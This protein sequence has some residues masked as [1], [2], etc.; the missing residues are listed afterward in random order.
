MKINFLIILFTFLIFQT[1]VFAKTNIT[2]SYPYIKDIV[3]KIAKDKVNVS[4]L[5][6]GDWDPHFVIPKPSLI[7]ILRKTDLLI[8]NGAQLEIGW[9]PPIIRQSNNPEIQPGNK[10][11]LDLSTYMEMIQVPNNISR[12]QGDVHPFGNPHFHLNPDNI[13]KISKIISEKL[14]SVDQENCNF[15]ENNQK[16][17]SE[18]WRNK[19]IE[20]SKKLSKSNKKVLEY[21]RVFDYFLSY[22]GFTILNTLEP[23]P[24]IPPTPKHINDLINDVKK[25][26]I[27]YN[28]R[29]V[30]NP[31][32]PSI[33][34]SEKT[35]VKLI[36][37][38]HDINSIKEANDIF[39]LYEYFVEN[40]SK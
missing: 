29:A 9:L 4:S 25:D 2:T 14:C 12:A 28:L 38:P 30:Y 6:R 3:E 27:L 16:V 1:E 22:Y 20:W 24:G 33:Y 21:H 26:K 10:G 11:F 35:G 8:I 36:T 31:K 5:S 15:Y 23:L 18:K 32:D 39:D 7:S 13:L 17:F 40:L 34:L 19:M 37:L